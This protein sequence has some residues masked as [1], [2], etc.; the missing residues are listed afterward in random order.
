MWT[1]KPFDATVPG[2]NGSVA[3]PVVVNAGPTTRCS[4]SRGTIIFKTLEIRQ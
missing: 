2:K 1:R 3:G 4:Y